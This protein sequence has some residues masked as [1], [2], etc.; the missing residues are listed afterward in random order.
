VSPLK[1]PKSM[2]SVL[3]MST[4]EMEPQVSSC[5]PNR[6]QAIDRPQHAPGARKSIGRARRTKV[7]WALEVAHLLDT[8]YAHCDVVTL[9]MDNLNTHT[10]GAFY[11]AFE[12]D[13]AKAYLR[14][15]TFCYTPKHG[16][17]LNVEL[18][19]EPMPAGPSPR[20]TR[21]SS[22]RDRYLVAENQRQTTGC[23]LAIHNRRRPAKA[24]A[25]VP[26]NQDVRT[27][28]LPYE[29]IWGVCFRS[30]I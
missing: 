26:Q 30:M 27:H 19:D 28:Y 9:V 20:R 12:P 22:I 1:P 7:D 5:L 24:Q 4:S 10:K 25:T 8:R 3:T 18:P 2:A 6:L 23:G 15:L 16:S 21:S 29:L 14:R 17:W 13:K 11:E